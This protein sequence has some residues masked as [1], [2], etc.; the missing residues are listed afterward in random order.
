MAEKPNLFDYDRNALEAY[1]SEIGH[2]PF[3]A[4]QV[5]KWIYHH[6]VTDFSAMTNLSKSLRSELEQSVSN[7]C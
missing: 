3:R 4:R 6:G 5:L 2:K 7:D 1:F